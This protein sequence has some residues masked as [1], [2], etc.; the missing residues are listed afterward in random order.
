MRIRAA[1]AEIADVREY[2][3]EKEQEP[4]SAWHLG[5]GQKPLSDSQLYRWMAKADKENAEAYR[6]SRKKLLRR[7]LSMRRSIM[8]MALDASDYRAALAAAKDEAELLGLYPPKN[9]NIGGKGGPAVIQVIE[10][11]DG[12]GEAPGGTDGNANDP[13]ADQAAPSAEGVPPQ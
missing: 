6:A 7:H 12:P 1:G 10:V 8:G 5:E 11:V 13:A 2:V 3:R 9:I 4:G